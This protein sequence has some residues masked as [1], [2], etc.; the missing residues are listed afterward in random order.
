MAVTEHVVMFSSGAGSW[1]A[2]RRVVDRHGCDHLT[3][4][5]CDTKGS[6]DSP[7]A[8]EDEDN[9]RFLREAACDVGGTLVWLQDGRDVWQ[10]FKDDR[11]IGNTRTANCSKFLKQRVAR[12]WLDENCDPG[13]TVVYVGI[14]WTE[15]HRLPAITSHYD[16]WQVD[17][18]LTEPPYLD[19]ADILTALVDRNIVPPRLYAM[20]FPHANCGGFCVRAGH[21]QFLRLLQNMPERFA[22]HEAKEQELRG[23]LRKDVAILRDRTGGTTKPLTLTAFRQR[24]QCGLEVDADDIGGCGCF[25]DVTTQTG[26]ENRD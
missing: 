5:F 17:A 11:M 23:H 20:G 8:G 14:D 12:R 21:G 16:P 24:V 25:V 6:N 18:P 3:L 15:V 26:D 22:Y 4:V 13:Q 1:A 2:A 19:K 10:V 7:H 9:Y